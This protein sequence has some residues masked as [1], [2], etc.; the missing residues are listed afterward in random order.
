MQSAR[1]SVFVKSGAEGVERVKNERYAYL[2]E[3]PQLEYVVERNCDLQQVGG[4]LDTKSYGIALP[5]GEDTHTER[6]RGGGD[7]RDRC[8]VVGRRRGVEW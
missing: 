5:P 4:L 7:A 2:M 3:S 1:P 6:E 8:G